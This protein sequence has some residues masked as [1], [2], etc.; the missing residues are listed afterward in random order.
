MVTFQ[1]LQAAYYMVAATG[2][3]VAAFYYIMNLRYTLKTKEMDACKFLTDRMTSDPVMQTYG[4]IMSK[5]VEW[6]D[7]DEFMD[8]YGYSNP[9]ML[10]HWTSWFFTAEALGYI[11]KNGIVRAETV[12]DLGGWGF[13]RMWE[14]FS[15]FVYSRRESAAWG[16]DYYVNFEYTANEMLK[17]KKKR[18]SEFHEKLESIEQLY[19][20]KASDEYIAQ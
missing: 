5:S 2:V 9:E 19:R 12:Y 7:H 10:G 8:K 14:K 18:D 13:I 11:M 6:K 20:K 4:I 17:I 1:D 3:L 15:G 16:R